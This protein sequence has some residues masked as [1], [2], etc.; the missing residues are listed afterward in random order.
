ME[1]GSVREITRDLYSPRFP[2]SLEQKHRDYYNEDEGIIS[3]PLFFPEEKN[4]VCSDIH[5]LLQFFYSCGYEGTCNYNER[6]NYLIC[7]LGNGIE[8]LFIL[9]ETKPQEIP[10]MIKIKPIEGVEDES[11]DKGVIS[12]YRSCIFYMSE[13]GRITE[14]KV[15]SLKRITEIYIKE[16]IQYFLQIVEKELERSSYIF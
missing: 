5:S 3:V 6:M 15:N 13:R 12:C 10:F 2:R 9:S 1:K 16:L 14:F 8:N 7:R 4:C 11:E